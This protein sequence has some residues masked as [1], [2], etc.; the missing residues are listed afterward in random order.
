MPPLAK[1]RRLG[2]VGPANS[3]GE[4]ADG[5]LIH[6][7]YVV[8]MNPRREVFEGGYVATADDGSIAAV[9][10]APVASK[11]PLS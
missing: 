1:F 5:I 2:G 4:G 3:P 11:Y 9:G 6:N 7:G 8:T 10:S